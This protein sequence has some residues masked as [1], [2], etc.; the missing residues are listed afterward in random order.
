MSLRGHVLHAQDLE[1]GG[2]ERADRR[3]AAR[4]RALDEDL[5]LL[6]AVLHALARTGVGR[7]L[8][9][10]RRRL[11]RA[12]EA[13]GA[14]GLPGDHVALLVGERD[15]RVVERRLDVRLADRDV[16]PDTA[17]GATTGR[18]PSRRGHLLALL[19]AA[20]GLLRALARTR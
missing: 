18:L 2:L 16:L 8:R 5:D 9:C 6:Q 10:E 1:A 19:A 4:P 7:D 20:D 3:L 11:A 14:G 17:A 15:D 12:L 13:R